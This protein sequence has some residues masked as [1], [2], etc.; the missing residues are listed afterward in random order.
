MA[1]YDLV[2]K[3]LDTPV[4]N[5]LGGRVRDRV[6][7]SHSLSMGDPQDIVEQATAQRKKAIRHSNVKSDATINQTSRYLM[8]S[9]QK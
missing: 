6:L 1:L 9:E 3:M 4:Y 8:Q 5:L 2:G 7:L